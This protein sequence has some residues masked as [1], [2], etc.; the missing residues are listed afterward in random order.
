MMSRCFRRRDVSTS[1]VIRRSLSVGLH[2]ERNDW[3]SGIEGDERKGGH[4]T[5]WQGECTFRYRVAERVA[6]LAGFQRSQRKQSFEE[7]VVHNTNFSVGA[8]YAF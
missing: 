1:T 5:V 8:T 4:E 6:I 7:E 2:F 3:T